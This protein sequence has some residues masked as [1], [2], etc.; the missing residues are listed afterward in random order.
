MTTV[1]RVAFFKSLAD[2]S[3]LEILESLATAPMYVEQLS[4]R[5]GIT[6][7][8][9]SF[10]LKKLEASG[11]VKPRKEQ[12]YTVYSLDETILNQTMLAVIISGSQTLLNQREEAYR[13][14]VL[15]NFMK[16]GKLTSIPVQRKKRQIVLEKL[17]DSFEKGRPYTEK[18]VNLILADFNDDFCTLRREMIVCGLMTRDKGIYLRV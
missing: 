8:T 10:H 13:Q 18:E 3:R 14:D 15:K 9:V 5:L 7:P 4:Q 1:E 6:P 12:Y 11:L 16:Y 2:K 17:V